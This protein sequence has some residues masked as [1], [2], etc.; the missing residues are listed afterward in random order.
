MEFIGCF[1]KDNNY[2]EMNMEEVKTRFEGDDA[3]QAKEA[4]FD[5]WRNSN[6]GNTIAQTFKGYCKQYYNLEIME[7]VIDG[8][9]I[10]ITT[11]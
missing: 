5:W 10:I 1:L 7:P 8:S 6:G 11:C 2:K 4:F 3:D 9:K